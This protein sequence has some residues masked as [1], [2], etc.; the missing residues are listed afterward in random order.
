MSQIPI[1]CESTEPLIDFFSEIKTINF[2]HY[3]EILKVLNRIGRGVLRTKIS[4][5]ISNFKEY[6]VFK[7]IYEYLNVKS[8]EWLAKEMNKNSFLDSIL[9][10]VEIK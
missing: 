8:C 2:V 9:K 3:P 7:F 5:T 6:E 1:L 10:T 4:E